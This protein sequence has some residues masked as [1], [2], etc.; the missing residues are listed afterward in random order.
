M[1]LAHA[2]GIGNKE[3]LSLSDKNPMIDPA[4]SVLIG[5]RDLDSGE[6]NAIR[7]LG[8]RAFTMRDIDELGMRTVMQEAIRIAATGTEGIHV[9]FDVDS[10][11]PSVAAG[12]GTPVRGGLTYREGHL[13]MEMLHDSNKIISMDVAEVNP[14]LDVSNQTADM[15]VEMILSAFGKGIL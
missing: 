11:D 14:V 4:R 7:E 8:V 2:L 12:V 13:A 5:I 3:L 9:S 1:P 10:M 15:A 6:K